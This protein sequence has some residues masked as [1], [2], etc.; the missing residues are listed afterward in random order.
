VDDGAG[1]LGRVDVEPV[2]EGDGLRPRERVAVQRERQPELV[3]GPDP[4]LDAV[5]LELDPSG[6]N[7]LA[8]MVVPSKESIPIV[9]AFVNSVSPVGSAAVGTLPTVTAPAA[10]TPSDR[11]TVRR[12]RRLSSNDVR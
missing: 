12:D 7:R 10:A 5:E 2:V 8:S 9:S 3:V 11:S 4:A 1:G 6:T